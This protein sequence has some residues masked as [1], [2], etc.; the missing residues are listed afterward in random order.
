[1]T[2]FHVLEVG[3]NRCLKSSIKE[4]GAK[5]D[6]KGLINALEDEDVFVRY[7]AEKA[8]GEIGGSRTVDPL[9]HTLKIQG[10]ERTQA[11]ALGIAATRT[12]TTP[13]PPPNY[14]HT[15]HICPRLH[16]HPTSSPRM[17]HNSLQGLATSGCTLG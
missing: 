17:P 9:I 7:R 12:Q 10:F 5:I 2:D 13:A 8:L 3:L 6:I 11:A 15:P 1:M 16:Q 4:I 14:H